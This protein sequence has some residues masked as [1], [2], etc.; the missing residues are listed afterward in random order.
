MLSAERTRYLLQKLIAE[1]MI[2]VKDV[3]KELDISETTIRRD[4]IELESEGKLRRVHGGAI[5]GEIAR[6]LSDDA[7]LTMIE[8]VSINY[9]KKFQIA[10]RA[11]EFVKDGECV[12]IDGGTS[13]APLIEYLSSRKIKIV[14]HSDLIVRQ[15]I[16]PIAEVFVVGGKY[17]PNYSMT[18]GPIAQNILQQFNF[19]RAFIGCAGIGLE[20]KTVYTAE[21]ETRAIK[22]IAIQNSLH[23]YLLIDDSKLNVRGFCKFTS[24]DRFEVIFCNAAETLPE[25]LPDN[26]EII[27]A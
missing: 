27:Q 8:R 5:K 19:D 6:I 10:K 26:V 18:V 3:A 9:E 11:S 17:L 21:A 24:T 4:L 23:N 13:T 7:E 20:E 14:T 1:G 25:E 2:S 12:F 15:L 22:E 16:N